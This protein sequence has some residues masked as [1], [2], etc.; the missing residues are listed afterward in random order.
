MVY[1]KLKLICKYVFCYFLMVLLFRKKLK[2]CIC[3][4][5]NFSYFRFKKKIFLCFICIWEYLLYKNLLFFLK[6]WCYFWF[7]FVIFI[8]NYKLIFVSFK[9]MILFI[10]NIKF[11]YLGLFYLFDSIMLFYLLGVWL[12]GLNLFIVF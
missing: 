9:I 8:R 4:K 2:M 1:I 12:I 3:L 5:L 6:K 11:I 10:N 7:Y